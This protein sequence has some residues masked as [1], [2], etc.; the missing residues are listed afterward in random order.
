MTRLYIERAIDELRRGRAIIID[1]KLAVMPVDFLTDDSLDDFEKH[2]GVKADM[3]VSGRRATALKLDNKA[4]AAGAYAV[5]IART[6]WQDVPALISIADPVHDLDTPLKG[7]FKLAALEDL[8]G[9]ASAAIALM[10]QAALLPAALM[11]VCTHVPPDWTT[12]NSTDI[13]DYPHASAAHLKIVAKAKVPLAGAQSCQLVAFRAG[14]GSLEHLAIIIGDPVRQTPVLTRLHSECFTG[15]LLG[16]LKCDCGTQLQGAIATMSSHG[17]GVLLYLAQ[18]G[19]GIGLINKLRAYGLQD[20]GFDT[21]DANWRLGFETDERVFAPAA[22][23]LKQ[24]GFESVRLLTNNP[25]K[26]TSLEA[27][28]ITVTERVGH[29]FP[30]NPHNSHYLI[31]KKNRTGH[32]F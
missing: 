30:S 13:E 11:G 21:V 26:V 24:L 23:M 31:T 4:V 29:S 3:L 2:I 22:Q 17:S 8:E 15:D 18:E 9:A 32:T 25:D 28:G 12:V 5:R 20:Q 1:D 6:S 10:K 27:L 7:P 16:S 14:S 19:R